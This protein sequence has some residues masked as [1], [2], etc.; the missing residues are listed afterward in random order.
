ML[1][2]FSSVKQSRRG[3]FLW[4]FFKRK[5]ILKFIVKRKSQEMVFPFFWGMVSFVHSVI[6]INDFL[7]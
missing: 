4:I 2:S 7:L 1:Y 3:K 5:D 6:F